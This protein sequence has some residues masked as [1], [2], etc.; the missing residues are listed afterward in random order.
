MV[1]WPTRPKSFPTTILK[2]FNEGDK[3]LPLGSELHRWGGGTTEKVAVVQ[4][5]GHYS[6]DGC[7][8]AIPKILYCWGR[9]GLMGENM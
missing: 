9:E 2:T 8:Q 7:L 3:F 6:M 1:I 4:L 5:G